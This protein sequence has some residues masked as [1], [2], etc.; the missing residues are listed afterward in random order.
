[1][2]AGTGNVTVTLSVTTGT[3]A[4]ATGGGVTV[5]GSGTGTVTLTGTVA[6]INSFIVGSGVTYSTAARRQ[7]RP[8]VDCQHRRRRQYRLRRRKTDTDT[9]TI[10][11]TPVN[12]APV[13]TVPGTITI[14]EDVTTALTGISVAD[15]DAGTGNITV[16]LSV[17]GGTLAATSSGTVTVGGTATALT[18]T[19]TL[20]DINAFLLGASVTYTTA[21]NNDG[22]VNLTVT[23][24]DKGNRQRR[25][26][27]D[28]EVITLDVQP[29]T[30]HRS[31]PC[32]QAS[33][34]PRMW[35][36]DITGISFSDVDAGTNNVTVTLFGLGGHADGATG[37]GVAVSGSGTD[38]I[39]LTG[40]VAAINSFIGGGSVDYTTP[41]TLTAATKL[42]PSAS[43]TAATPA[44]AAR[45]PIPKPSPQ[46]HAVNDAPVLT[47]PGSISIDED[48]TTALTG[49]SVADDDGGT[50]NMTVTLSVHGDTLTATLAAASGRRAGRRPDL[51][52]MPMATLQLCA[53]V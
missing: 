6:A 49:I 46:C 41:Q 16:T 9:V 18:L 11:V 14:D 21:L 44:R 52:G 31:R 20:A 27:V 51:Q 32:R 48:V 26:Q 5:V 37:G 10:N 34:S 22:D 8:D 39:T 2:D 33:P 25:R 45:R 12:D 15:V 53:A 30:T 3:L 7:R 19:G 28:S 4:A 50:G 1:M 13:L 17:P 24:N 35:P 43:T 29:S 38:S 47:V 42:L 36:R 23:V 40:T